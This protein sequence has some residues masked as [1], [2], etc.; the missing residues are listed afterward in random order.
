MGKRTTPANAFALL[1]AA[2]HALAKLASVLDAWS[3]EVMEMILSGRK[4]VD[5]IICT[6]S[7]AWFTS[8]EWSEIM[9]RDGV[10]FEE[11]GVD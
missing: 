2:E 10:A 3:A 6:K 1:F 9:E 5:V 4:G 8:R 7:E 11:G